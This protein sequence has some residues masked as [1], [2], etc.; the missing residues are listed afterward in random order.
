MSDT[1]LM[2]MLHLAAANISEVDTP[3]TCSHLTLCSSPVHRHHGDGWIEKLP[4]SVAVR[5]IM[6]QYTL[7]SRTLDTVRG[8]L[9][10]SLDKSTFPSTKAVY[11]DG[12]S[13]YFRDRDR[14]K[15]APIDR[16]TMEAVLYSLAAHSNSELLAGGAPLSSAAV[17]RLL[18]PGT[19]QLPLPPVRRS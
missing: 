2:A 7:V 18:P 16:A 9:G 8:S 17:H 4:G 3:M 10:R 14:L 5:L 1:A 6:P 15:A 19:P 12:T 13:L 11:A